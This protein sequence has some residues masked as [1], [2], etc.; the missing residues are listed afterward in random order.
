[1]TEL[2]AG[3]TWATVGELCA[4]NPRNFTTT[5]R[6]DDLISKVPMAAVEAESGHLNGS[7]LVRYGDV[8]KKSLT[9]FEENDVL[10]AKVTPCMENGKIALAAGLKGGRA[11]GSTELFALRS[12][13]AIEPKYLMYFLIQPSVRKAAER[14]MTGAV[15]LRRV[16]RSHLESLRIPLP[17]INEQRRIVEVLEDHLARLGIALAGLNSSINRLSRF[18]GQITALAGTGGL[19]LTSGRHDGYIKDGGLDDGQL[20][21]IAKGWQWKR[22]GEIAEVVGGVT[23]DSKKQFDPTYID[24]PY[25]RVAN[26]QR[27]RIV[28]DEVSHI[29][30]PRSKLDHLRLQF[31]DVLLNEG[32]DRDKLGRGWI[33]ENQIQD[34]I[35]QNHI[36]RARVH[37]SAIHPKL[38]AWHTNSFGKIW[39]D[40]NAKQTVNLASISL[41]KIKMLPVPVPPE[42][43][44]QERLIAEVESQLAATSQVEEAL[45]SAI[46]QG[47]RLRMKILETAFSGN[48]IPQDPAD[49]PVSALLDRI[50]AERGNITQG[51]RRPKKRTRPQKETLL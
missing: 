6:D 22:L 51:G 26:V 28:L 16:P 48:L 3:W 19:S 49:E 2:P 50:R 44:D 36:F 29:R 39:C 15:G 9:P 32:G 8:K 18:R 17:S 33:W 4:I 14:A 34:C 43:F 46:R 47:E 41:K 21:K 45:E 27:G 12:F 7:Q 1:M 25:L 42:G 13:G 37:E 10:F 38:L 20:P 23:K 35:H 40:R 5:P 31:G 30:V 11:V 24:V